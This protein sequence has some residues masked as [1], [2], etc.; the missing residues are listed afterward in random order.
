MML[1]TTNFA[2]FTNLTLRVSEGHIHLNILLVFPKC[3][4]ILKINIYIY[5]YKTAVLPV[6]L[7]A[8]E[9]WCV[10]LRQEHGLRIFQRVA[11]RRI[12]LSETKFKKGTYKT[13]L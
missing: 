8:S 7:H 9:T 11:L 13:A 3:S 1:K 12:F 4:K 6:V 2:N 10:S 5:V